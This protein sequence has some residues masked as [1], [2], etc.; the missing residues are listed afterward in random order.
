MENIEN[1]KKITPFEGVT[2]LGA[3]KI[4]KETDLPDGWKRMFENENFQIMYK[5]AD[6]IIPGISI[7]VPTPNEDVISAQKVSVD[8]KKIKASL[9]TLFDLISRNKQISSGTEKP[10]FD[11]FAT[12]IRLDT[13]NSPEEKLSTIKIPEDAKKIIVEHFNN[14][15]QK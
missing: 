3:N 7:N 14:L 13:M 10:A 4:E 1:F 6:F 8:E 11:T 12:S 9:Y 2:T 15:I 5:T